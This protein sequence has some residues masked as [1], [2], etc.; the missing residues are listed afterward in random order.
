V[1]GTRLGVAGALYAPDCE[2][3]DEPLLTAR[4]GHDGTAHES[5][6]MQRAGIVP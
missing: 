3:Q 2:R 1:S 4:W 5:R 6:Q